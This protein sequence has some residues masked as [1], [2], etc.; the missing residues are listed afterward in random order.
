MKNYIQYDSN[1]DIVCILVV[2]D[3]NFVVPTETIEINENDKQSVI[4]RQRDFKVD[5]KTKKMSEVR[6]PQ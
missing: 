1:G 2:S 4:G 6:R 3:P 5:K